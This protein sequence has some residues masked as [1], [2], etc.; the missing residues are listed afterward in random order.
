M[1]FRRLIRF[2]LA[3]L[4]LLLPL[5]LHAAADA[6]WNAWEKQLIDE[7]KATEFSDAPLDEEVVT[8][9]WF[10]L[11]FLDLRED[12]DEAVR[13]GKRGLVV[14]FGQ[15][16]CPYCRALMENNFGQADIAGYT[17]EHFDVVAIN[18]HGDRTVT[19]INGRE[20]SEKAYAERERTNFTPSLVFYDAAGKEVLRLTGY[21][22]PYQFRAALEYVADGHYR[23]AS[24]RQ[25]LERADPNLKAREGDLHAEP[26]FS[27]PPYLLDRSR[28]AAE[29]PLIV[30]FEQADCHACDVLHTE[31]L[32]EPAIRELLSRFD[33]VQL[34]L[35]AE[36]P[37]LTPRGERLT[38][39]AWG[40][41][42]GLFY[43]P[44]LLFFDTDGNEILRVDSVIH[45][46]RLRRT[47]EY[48]LA[49]AYRDGTTLQRWQREGH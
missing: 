23:D 41:Q 33:T 24:F 38:S 19:D 35:W 15:K 27:P 6:E 14:Y 4:L 49:G 34:G 16:F 30:L 13:S 10:R 2:G 11:S 25:Y 12:L 39:R 36:N 44:T 7:A 8:P 42:L 47:L 3:P 20:W 26:F 43:T 29:R 9:P 46:N 48:V 37:V 17:R 40:E 1:I 28:I 5:V 45:F 32:R 31:P 22:P 21:Y 18:I